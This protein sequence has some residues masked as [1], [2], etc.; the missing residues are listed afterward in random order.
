MA[1]GSTDRGA[2]A[3]EQPRWLGLL[4]ALLDDAP[5]G[6][7]A[8]GLRRTGQGAAELIGCRCAI[9]TVLDRDGAL[10]HFVPAGPDGQTV[11]R[12]A[13]LPVREGPLAPVVDEGRTVRLAGD[14]R[15]LEVVQLTA[16]LGIPVEADGAVVG[17]LYLCDPID[18]ATFT[19]GDEQLGLLFARVAAALIQR[20]RLTQAAE[21]RQRW[22]SES[23]ALTRALLSGD[24][25]N[26]LRLVVERVRDTADADLVAVVAERVEG[27]AYE[28]IEAAGPHAAALVGRMVSA[29]A[30]ASRVIVEGVPRVVSDLSSGGR[31]AELAD[32]VG[33]ESAV[34]VPLSGAGVDR[35]L[36]AMYRRPERPGFNGAEMD[37]AAMFAAQLSLA[38]ELADSRTKRERDV[39]L[40][41]RGRIAR[42]LHD[43]VIQRLFA[44]G[45]TTQSVTAQVDPRASARLQDCVDGIDQSIAQIRS[46]IYRLTGP[47]VS[48]E[49]SIRTR[50]AR[51]VEDMAPVLGFR[52]EL[53]VRGPV[54]FGVEDDL[55]DDC[56]AVLREA[57]TNAAKHAQANRVTVTITVSAAE[58]CL[59]VGDDGRG[60]GAVSRR[61]GLANLRTRAERRGG[62]LI[63]ASGT[64]RG[65]RLTWTVPI[66]PASQSVRSVC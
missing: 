36:L 13:R 53:D 26:P 21:Q 6:P 66:G 31:H 57:I 14:E 33:A 8:D 38:L 45:L 48:G 42:D 59:E 40:D 50:A 54:D 25:V 44:I 10:E 30:L 28:V 34:L 32:L 15:G 9:V 47:L 20:A 43:H 22:L 3:D 37:A 2:I 58:L 41:D 24:D 12:V 17:G 35:G 52:A 1:V 4:R 49:N 56:V 51:L 46:T 29:A 61:S 27:R 11:D 64:P 55:T 5:A 16:V 7:L 63:V 60:I 65:T 19:D 39:L 23:A 62:R 18:R